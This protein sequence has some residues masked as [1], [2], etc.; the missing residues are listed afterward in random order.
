MHYE[1]KKLI[2]KYRDKIFFIINIDVLI[3]FF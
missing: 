3:F 2:K 1:H